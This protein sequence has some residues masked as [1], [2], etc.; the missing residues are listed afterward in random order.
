MGFP[1]GS[2]GKESICNAGDLDS[3]RGLGRSP[4]GGRGNPLQ[5][6]CLENPYGQR[7]LAG[8]SPWDCKNSDMTELLS[9]A[10]HSNTY[11]LEFLKWWQIIEIW[12]I[13]RYS[14][15]FLTFCSE[16]MCF[17]E[18]F[19][20]SFIPL[21]GLLKLCNCQVMNSNLVRSSNH[22]PWK[23]H[24]LA[25]SRYTLGQLKKDVTSWRPWKSESDITM[26][27]I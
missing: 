9:T 16:S 3:I 5:Y 14:S 19:L 8:C 17:W 20:Q 27:E 11:F 25:Y 21:S 4:G 12:L 15:I 1:G 6:P 23:T 13:H 24:R 22:F 7:S 2:D 18:L 26:Q 10:Q